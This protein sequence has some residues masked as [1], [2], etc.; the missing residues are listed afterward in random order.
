MV[1]QW[2][3]GAQIKADAQTAGAMC[4]ELASE[5]RLTAKNL[6]DANRPEDAPLHNAFEWNDGVAAEAWRE[7]QARHM[8]NCL[9]IRHETVEPT[10]AFFKIERTEST[11][12]SIS[13]IL[14]SE[15]STEKLLNTALKELEAF[16][17]KYI[18]LQQLCGVFRAI[19]EV[20]THRKDVIE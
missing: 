19:D 8:I 6:L 17:R 12:Q 15:N 3:A 13:T 7:Q 20:Q 14:S 10:R 9:T 11:Y 2:K 5:G 1:Y 18:T 16:K 4:M